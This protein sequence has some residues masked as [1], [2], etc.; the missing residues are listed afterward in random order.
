MTQ[1]DVITE[2]LKCTVH[3]TV[4]TTLRCNK[5]GRP[6]CVKCSVR[7][8][9]G[10]RCKEC[11]KGQQSVFY[12]NKAYDPVIQ[13]VLS[14]TL[15]LVAGVLVGMIGGGLGYWGFFIMGAVGAFIGALIADLAHRVVGRRRSRYGWL[16]VAAGIVI[17]ALPGLPAA[18]VTGGFFGLIPLAIYL[19]T[20]VGA[21]VGRLRL[22]R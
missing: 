5:C 21:A 16:I 19:A 15:G 18:F 4:D 12:N 13:G 2:T 7:T 14:L 9:V 1:T 10:Y 17:G 6:M 8:P 3:P 20:A 22:G 11:V